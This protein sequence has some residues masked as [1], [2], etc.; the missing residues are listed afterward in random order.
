MV[1]GLAAL[2]R[3]T[4]GKGS[5]GQDKGHSACATEILRLATQIDGARPIDDES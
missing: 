4:G 2:I 1:V 3:R 5:S